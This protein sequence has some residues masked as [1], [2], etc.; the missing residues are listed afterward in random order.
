MKQITTYTSIVGDKDSPRED[1]IKCFTG[2]GK[3]NEPVMEAKI[4]KILAHQFIESDYSIWMDGNVELL[5][6]PEQLVEEWLEDKYDMAL[7]KHP[8]R[9]CLY[10]EANLCRI[11]F[12]NQKLIIDEQVKYYRN[13][14]FPELYGLTECCIIV[15]KHSKEMERLN[16]AWWSEVCRWSSRDQLSL[17]YVLSKFPELKVKLIDGNAREHPYF[18]YTNHLI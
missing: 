11:L 3:F 18:N 1:K 17:P 12:S 2:Q 13:K 16:N 4:Y 14:N 9:K 7:W 6:P 10:D 15:R 8:Y 5:I